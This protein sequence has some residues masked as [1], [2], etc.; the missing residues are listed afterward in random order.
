ME[1]PARTQAVT[2][3]TFLAGG[4]ALWASAI[5]GK[6]FYLQV[7]R[8]K[9]YA[10]AASE[11]QLEMV[12]IP[13]PRGSIFDRN[14]EILA[15]SE[16]V[17]SVYV[18]PMRV[19]NLAVAADIL[20]PVLHLN[21]D[22]LYARL[23]SSYADRKRHGFCWVKQKITREEK[24]D[25]ES[26]RLP[27]IKLKA[28]SLRHYPKLTVASHVIGS[29]D[30]AEKGDAGLELSLDRELRG[31]AG[32]EQMLHDVKKRG[33]ESES[34]DEPKV[35]AN[36]VLTIDE[37]IQSAAERELKEAVEKNKA[38]TGTVVVMNPSNG[39]VL[40]MASYPTFDPNKRPEPGEPRFARLNRAVA[41]PFEPGS[42]FKVVTLTAALE[43]T[44]LRPESILPCGSI[45]MFH[46]VIHE[47]HH[48]WGPLSMAD[49]LAK[50]SNVGA[51]QIGMKVGR[52]KLYEY[53]RRFGF[54]Q[55]TGT[56][57]PAESGGMLRK[58]ERW[59]P[60][61]I[62]SIPMGHEISVTAMQLARA[63]SVVANGGLLV[64]PKLI[65]KRQRAGEAM[66]EEKSERPVRIIRPETAFTMRRMMEGVVVLP[67]GTGHRTARLDG[68][69]AAG[70]TGSAQIY[71]YAARHY[72]KMYNASFMGFAPVTNPA[73]V[74]VVTLNG[75]TGTAG[76]G[77][78]A[79]GPVFRTVAMEALRVL[80]VPK[81]I[82]DAEPA[83]EDETSDDDVR[84]A[85]NDVAIAGVGDPPP[86]E[87]TD[88]EA[89]VQVAAE[90]PKPV[91]APGPRV[92]NF[93]GMTMRAVIEEASARGLPVALDGRGVARLQVPSPGA[94]LPPGG[95]VRVVFAR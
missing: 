77:G 45:N 62:C 60:G 10:E 76:Y 33:I 11:Q 7:L 28:D 66:E 19:P 39:E 25:I 91:E 59:Q 51:I 53:V 58:L 34:F 41:A 55:K 71:D 42:V 87:E 40:A 80:D 86:A 88:E 38:R 75:T 82:P 69:S 50:S 26:M 12:D 35:G 73:I 72:T 49:V 6:L 1:P 95:K 61:S 94:V 18:S 30:H 90:K 14:L 89:P 78:A 2:R 43:T 24:A 52:E 84:I 3:T 64:K 17:D 83:A 56:G 31:E 36:L 67:Y 15:M 92:P 23:K 70:K 27:W 68:Y 29:V 37:R 79:A 63:C 16:P 13:A 74:V 46:R 81:D 9:H 85:E 8:H 21:R 47:A 57:L 32:K 44:S 93:Q 5:F 54:G 48:A 22:Q 65:L 4:A 20:A